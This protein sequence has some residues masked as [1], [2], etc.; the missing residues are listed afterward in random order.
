MSC[1]HGRLLST[2]CIPFW[3]MWS[4]LMCLC[5]CVEDLFMEPLST[6]RT[7]HVGLALDCHTFQF[8]LDVVCCCVMFFNWSFLTERTGWFHLLVVRRHSDETDK[9]H[10]HLLNEMREKNS[11]R[12]AGSM[13]MYIT[14]AYGDEAA[15]NRLRNRTWSSE[16]R[17]ETDH[18]ESLPALEMRTPN[19][20]PDDS[21]SGTLDANSLRFKENF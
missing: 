21:V 19:S 17:L 6:T 20:S 12:F 18:P 10:L 16:H 14:V 8:N 11:S 3:V 15:L 1:A 13:I 9:Q 4:D 5:V 7:R 2:L